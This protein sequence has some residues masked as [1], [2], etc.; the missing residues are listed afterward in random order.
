M[1]PNFYNDSPAW[2]KKASSTVLPE[3]LSGVLFFTAVSVVPPLV[4]HTNG[5]ELQVNTGAWEACEGATELTVGG[6][7][8]AGNPGNDPCLLDLSSCVVSLD[9]SSCCTKLVPL[10]EHPPPTSATRKA[11]R[12]VRLPFRQLLSAADHVRAGSSITLASRNLAFLFW[13]HLPP[14]TLDA[15]Q[16]E[17]EKAKGMLE[18]RTY[19]NLVEPFAVSVKV[20]SR[21]LL[22]LL[23]I[24]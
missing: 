17:I 23:K 6:R 14:T 5:Y 4:A 10:Q 8:D 15:A 1:S 22:L 18:K 9:W 20:R 2:W 16:L 3:I 19:I 12:P 21:S 24:D 7:S 13:L 11:A